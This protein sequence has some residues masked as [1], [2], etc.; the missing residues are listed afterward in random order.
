MHYAT[1]LRRPKTGS[2]GARM[3]ERWCRGAT[4]TAAAMVVM[5]GLTAG[6][7]A[8]GDGNTTRSFWPLPKNPEVNLEDMFRASAYKASQGM[9]KLL[10]GKENTR[11]GI[12]SVFGV[13]LPTPVP[14]VVSNRECRRDVLSLIRTW[15]NPNILEAVFAKGRFWPSTMPDSWGK[16]PDGILYGNVMPWGLQEECTHIVADE[17]IGSPV[18]VPPFNVIF[19]GRYC[20]VSVEEFKQSPKSDEAMDESAGIWKALGM[21]DPRVGVAMVNKEVPPIFTYGTCMPSSCTA[22][23]LRASIDDALQPVG[24]TAKFVDCHLED[25]PIEF[26]NGDIFF[27]SFLSVLF[28]VLLAAAVVD[29][30]IN[31]LEK[32][33]LRKGPLKFLLVFSAYSNMRSTFTIRPK[34]HPD[35][36]SCLHGLRVF[37]MGWVVLGHG[38]MFLA[39]V[40]SNV[41]HYT[42]LSDD[43]LDQIVVN[44]SFSV[45]TFLFMSGLVVAYTLLL[46]NEKNKRV[47]WLIYYVHRIIR[48]SPPIIITGA[49]MATVF[50]FAMVGPYSAN[51]ERSYVENCRSNWWVDAL[52]IGNFV[53]PPCL[54]QCWYTAVDFQLYAVAPLVLAPLLT[55][56]RLSGLVWLAVVTL[57]SVAV[58][59]ITI[60]VNDLNP[61]GV[62]FVQ[63]EPKKTVD[64]Y[65]TPWARASPYLMGI[66]TG[67]LLMEVRGK[68]FKLHPVAVAVGWMVSAAIA[69]A[70]LF[71]MAD[72]NVFT[73]EK[74]NSI[75][76]AASILYGGLSRLAWG[77]SLLWVVFACHTGY[78]GIANSILAHPS[79]QP[80][81]RLTYSLYLVTICIQIVYSGTTYV[82]LYV[83]HLNKAIETCGYLFLGGLVAIP[84]NLAVE[85][86]ILGLEKLLLPRP[87]RSV[88][89]QQQEQEEKKE[90]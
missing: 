88:T 5:V 87:G 66:W 22:E 21:H 49:A 11:A 27:I 42:E 44:A 45:D 4:G 48:L 52:F 80:V 18:A 35:V 73:F 65:G 26:T 61:P 53:S 25:E 9:S 36:I 71:G 72:Y 10:L 47:N 82:P 83:N 81:S 8:E 70:V 75:P 60:A 86:P 17:H 13:Y 62:P 90:E 54:P 2:G 23:D 19:R 34:E 39:S 1:K 67:W 51:I 3:K 84:L 14:G 59:M 15:I 58:P 29:L 43:V 79:L 68:K 41:V 7:M 74:D 33:E 57:V 38:Y 12:E 40:T 89:E 20:L 64:L 31:H 85:R 55:K 46:E 69:L 37:S 28:A 24:K 32:H 76:Q 63:G 16:V 30:C 78:G 77:V 6:V 50:R 56:K